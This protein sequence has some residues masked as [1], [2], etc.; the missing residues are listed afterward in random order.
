MPD[1]TPC[2]TSEASEEEGSL[3][4]KD[5]PPELHG[6]EDGEIASLAAGIMEQN[7]V[8]GEEGSEPLPTSLLATEQDL[9]NSLEGVDETSQ[10]SYLSH[11]KNNLHTPEGN[12]Q[13]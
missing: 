1:T 13:V 3:L 6:S 8:C 10:V 5:S 9:S 7:D 4:P 2:V 11:L 12:K